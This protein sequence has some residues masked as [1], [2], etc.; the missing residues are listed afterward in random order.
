MTPDD[1]TA[2]LHRNMPL[3]EAMGLR[4]LDAATGRIRLSA[5]LTPNRNLHGTAFGGSLAALGIVAG[6]AVLHRGLAEANVAASLVVHRSE[7]E[8]LKPATAELIADCVL[9]AADWP[10][11]LA[12]LREGRRARITVATD[13]SAG[14][15]QVLRVDA[16]YVALPGADAGGAT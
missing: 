3:T 9:P 7:L 15:V 4:V 1:Y 2:F 16:Q 14:G 12:T 13:V 6:W 10:A 8:Y 11:F 5:P